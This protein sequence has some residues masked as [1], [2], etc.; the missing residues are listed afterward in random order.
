VLA[1]PEAAVGLLPTAGGTQLLPWLVGEPWAKRMILLGERIDA[2]TA[3]RI[4]L[5]DEVVPAGQAVAK[6]LELAAKVEKQSPDSVAACK[7]LIQA[8][9]TGPLHPALAAEREKFLGLFDGENQK[10]GVQ[11][12]LEKRAPQWK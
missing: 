11:A 9:R 3:L 2:A 5:V 10:E 4:G 12:F 7:H 8:A 6:A 1:L